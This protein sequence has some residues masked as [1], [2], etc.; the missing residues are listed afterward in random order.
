MAQNNYVLDVNV[1]VSFIIG[2]KLFK[3]A[4]FTEA[5]VIIYTSQN[6]FEE[7]LD[8]LNRP[9]IKKYLAPPI[10]KYIQ[11][12][13]N[14]TILIDDISKSAIH[15]PDKNDNYLFELAHQ[16]DSVLVTGDKELLYWKNSP[17]AF[18]SLTTFL[19]LF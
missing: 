16:T 6:L 5:G 19:K 18:I 13:E 15:S 1:Y 2:K 10:S 11:A 17:V 12:I 14:F 4:S 3:L 8:V 7:L 9:K